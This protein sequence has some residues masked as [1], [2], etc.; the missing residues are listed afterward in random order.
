MINVRV[1]ERKDVTTISAISDAVAASETELA[2]RGRVLLRPSGTEPV[3]RVMV[4]GED[5]AEVKRHAQQLVEVVEKEL[6]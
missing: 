6:A 1:V 3:I 4:E 2:G 5:A